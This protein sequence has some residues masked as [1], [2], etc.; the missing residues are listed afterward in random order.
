[1]VLVLACCEGIEAAHA[2]MTQP[3]PAVECSFMYG[4]F[5]MILDRFSRG[6]QASPHPTR[7][8]ACSTFELGTHAGCVL[9]GAC[10]PMGCPNWPPPKKNKTKNKTKNSS[11]RPGSTTAPT[12]RLTLTSAATSCRQVVG[13]HASQSLSIT[14]FDF[15]SGPFGA[16]SPWPS[17]TAC[18]G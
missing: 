2:L 14:P 8:A 5:D 11:G 10:N 17:S 1:M 7:S 13:R 16:A 18:S 9:I 15:R 4:N 12:W 6:S 3:A